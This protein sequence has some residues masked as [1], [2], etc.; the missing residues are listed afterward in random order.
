MEK[1]HVFFTLHP[2]HV[3]FSTSNGYRGTDPV[4]PGDKHWKML[5]RMQRHLFRSERHTYEYRDE[6]S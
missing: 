2:M 3:S 4:Y 5:R 1:I 6:R